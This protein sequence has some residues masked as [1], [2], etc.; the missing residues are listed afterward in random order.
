M[1]DH[2]T[3]P[4]A[5]ALAK[6]IRDYWAKQGKKVKT[7]VVEQKNPKPGGEMKANFYAVRSDMIGGMP[8][9]NP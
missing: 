6:R 1:T 4:G 2:L 3:L 5:T 9:T 8:R 7:E